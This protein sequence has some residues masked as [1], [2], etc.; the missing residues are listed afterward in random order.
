MN[1]R[2][3]KSKEMFASLVLMLTELVSSLHMI[4][5]L[6]SFLIWIKHVC[7]H[8]KRLEYIGFAE[9]PKCGTSYSPREDST[10]YIDNL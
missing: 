9:L 5:T 7:K 10:R 6:A 8:C 4:N 3:S 1:S 2:I